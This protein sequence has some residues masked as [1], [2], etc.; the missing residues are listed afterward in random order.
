MCIVSKISDGG[1]LRLGVSSVNRTVMKDTDMS[2]RVYIMIVH[3]SFVICCLFQ[4]D[5]VT[6][7]IA[8]HKMI[9]LMTFAL[10]GESYVNFMGNEFGHPDFVDVPRAGNN[11][12][13][14]HS[15]RRFGLSDDKLLKYK[16]LEVSERF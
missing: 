7:G 2:C 3:C 12:S 13:Y 6:R 4:N 15:N 9:R 16:H 14:Y 8:L 5:A 1:N 10:G 11:F